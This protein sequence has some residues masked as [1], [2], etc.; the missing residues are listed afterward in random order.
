MVVMQPKIV[1]LCLVRNEEFFIGQVIEN[2]REFCDHLIITDHQSRDETLEIARAFAR[3]YSNI[4]VHRIQHASQS[5]QFLAPYY[6]TRTWVFA[7]DGDEIYDPGRLRTF[8]KKLK[9]GELA[10]WWTVFGNV[11]HC[12]KLDIEAMHAG[13]YL[14]PP[15]RS[16]TKLYNFHAIREW[17]DVKSERLHGGSIVFKHGWNAAMRYDYYKSIPW[18]ESDFRCLHLCFIPRSPIDQRRKTKGLFSRPNIADRMNMRLKEKIGMYIG[19]LLG[20][21]RYSTLKTEKY[22]RG[23]FATRDIQPFFDKEPT[24]FPVPGK[25]E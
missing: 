4:E 1:G 11:L 23:A 2:I 22:M 24:G 12:T 7:V 3:R 13:G 16:M 9:N 20:L 5:Q 10:R 17:A 8:R 6:N 15:C 25:N 18:E 19:G 14:S 21:P